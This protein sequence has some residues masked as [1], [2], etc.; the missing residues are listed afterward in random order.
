MK[1]KYQDFVDRKVSHYG[2]K[3]SASELSEQFVRFY[4]SGDRVRV[5]FSYGEEVTGTVG[6]TTGWKPVFLLMRT[7]R[8]FGSSYTLG[9]ND[10]VVAVKYGNKY[11]TTHQDLDGREEGNVDGRC[12]TT[13]V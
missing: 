4:N 12:A 1:D 8:S 3:F 11:H 6:V 10:K 2:D 7:S 13:I 5:R 9:A